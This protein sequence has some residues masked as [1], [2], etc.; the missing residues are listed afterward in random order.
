M[1]EQ[2][3]LYSLVRAFRTSLESLAA[4]GC[5]HL[6]IGDIGE[7]LTVLQTEEAHLEDR[8]NAP[9]D[10]PAPLSLAKIREDL[11]DCQRCPLSATRKNLVFGNGAENARL[12]FVG[13]APG[14]SEDDEGIPFVGLSGQLL[15]KMI[16]AMG[17]SRD[18]VYVANVL[19]CRPPGNR[20]PRKEEVL[21]CEGVLAAQIES[22]APD[23]IVTLGKPAA[24]LLLQSTEAMG[25]LRGRWQSFQGIPV[26]P[27]Y[28]PA[29]LL[30]DASKKRDAWSDLQQVMA[31][32]QETS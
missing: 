30:R 15:D 24:H 9:Q 20:D 17:F 26:M 19:K 3:E 27:T 16:V 31:R 18:S 12:F 22:V 29:Y 6:P 4:K 2:A 8:V 21:A 14:E 10:A 25:A 11:G 7:V 13:E 5:S 28:H 23:V 1:S 32:L